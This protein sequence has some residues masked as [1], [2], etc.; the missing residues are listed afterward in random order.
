L[1]VIIAGILRSLVGNT[2]RCGE[3]ISCNMGENFKEL[4]SII[5]YKHIV[6]SKLRI[7][8]LVATK[9]HMILRSFVVLTWMHYSIELV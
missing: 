4:I 2:S 5:A 1:V 3:G 6:H 8:T 7:I 9:L